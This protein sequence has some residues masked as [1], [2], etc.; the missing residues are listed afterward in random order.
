MN[1]KLFSFLIF[2]LI[3]KT[4][5]SFAQ[6]IESKH[7]FNMFEDV[8]ITLDL[9]KEIS[10]KQKPTMLIIYALP[11]GNSTAWTM[12]KKMSAG[13]DWHFDIQ[14]IAAQTAFIRAALPQQKIVI[15]YL[16]P[17]IPIT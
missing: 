13:D 7:G 8:N 6:D 17:N 2:L 10:S 9:P 5:S 11:N 4:T 12:G 1:V 15:A 3:V 14:H 16:E